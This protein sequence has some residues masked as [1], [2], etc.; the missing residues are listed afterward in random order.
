MIV[1][2]PLVARSLRPR[3]ANLGVADGLTPWLA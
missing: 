2:V 3:P 1:V